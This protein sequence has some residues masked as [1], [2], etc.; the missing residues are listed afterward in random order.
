MKVNRVF[1]VLIALFL[2]ILASLP[3]LRSGLPPT[4]DGEYHVIRFYQFQRTLADGQWY[5]RWQPDVNNGY[6]SPLLNY[7]YPLPNYLASFLHIFGLS[8]I[9]SFKLE[10]VL[11]TLVGSVF[12]FLWAR[13]FW[14]D[15]GGVVAS[16]FY[17][18]SPYRF[19]DVY[20]RGSVGEVLALALFPGVLWTMTRLVREGGVNNMVLFS[21]L[22][23]LTVLSH[24][25]LALM[26]FPFALSY[27]FFLWFQ[28]G[29]KSQHPLATLVLP[30][31]LALG[32]TAIFWLPALLERHYVRGL[33]IFDYRHHFVELY[34]LVF[35]S[36]GSGF[37][38]DFA[39]SGLSVQVGIANLVVLILSLIGLGYL[40][41]NAVQK[42]VVLFM[43]VWTLLSVFLMLRVSQQFWTIIP[44]VK[45]FQFP[46][47]LLSLVIV[48]CAYLAG[49][50][51]YVW[52]KK[53]VAV[54]LIFLPVVLGIGYTK[55]AYYHQRD[56][57]YY[58]TRKNFIDGTNTPGNAFNTIWM[59]TSLQREKDRLRFKS[60]EGSIKKQFVKATHYSFLIFAKQKSEM[61]VHTAYFPG[62]TV[63]ID[64]NRVE[65]NPTK[66]GTML[67]LL[68]KGEHSVEVMFL[69]TPVRSIGKAVSIGSL[70][71]L[72][73]LVVQ[74]LRARMSRP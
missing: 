39:T 66:D 19:L 55:P 65:V 54:L 15:V 4:H 49:S 26:F 14:G 69:D 52:G 57:N 40:K 67:F 8:F 48:C 73:I 1:P 23:A 42:K 7:Y 64:G 2:A 22:L 18:Y 44:L 27:L 35:P 53:A 70:F 10:M 36:W 45:Y 11:A 5:P 56:D 59:N 50:V 9:D 38:A 20:V 12:A 6:G 60:G 3:L 17:T 32:L 71:F 21:L 72:A 51:V 46:W 31:F 43:L 74:G 34:Q 58:T 63:F 30:L 68:P 62:W 24:N 16:V 25:I 47:R 28:M 13:Q 41:K 29:K 61:I 33:E 37:S